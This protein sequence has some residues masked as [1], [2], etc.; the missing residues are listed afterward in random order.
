MSLLPQASPRSPMSKEAWPRRSKGCDLRWSI[1]IRPM[2]RVLNLWLANSYP[3]CGA[4]WYAARSSRCSAF[5]LR[6]HE[7]VACPGQEVQLRQECVLGGVRCRKLRVGW[8]WGE[9]DQDSVWEAVER[10]ASGGPYTVHVNYQF[11]LWPPHVS[12]RP[13]WILLLTPHWRRK[14]TWTWHVLC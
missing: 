12:T 10:S 13:N 3:R 11:F 1:V 14:I 8:W 4:G 9:R 5:P 7:C 2:T 6:Q